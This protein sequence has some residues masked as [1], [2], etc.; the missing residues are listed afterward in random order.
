MPHSLQLRDE[1]C[2][3][4]T[5]VGFQC[6]VAKCTHLSGT[7]PWLYPLGSHA[8]ALGENG[9]LLAFLGQ[10][11]AGSVLSLGVVGQFGWARAHLDAKR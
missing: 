2:T 7:F 1:E 8:V 9:F 4:V 10:H 11:G 3:G 5:K 6:Q